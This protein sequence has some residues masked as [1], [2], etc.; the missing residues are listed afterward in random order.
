VRGPRLWSVPDGLWSG[1]LGRDDTG[2]RSA[3]RH[4]LDALGADLLLYSSKNRNPV[5]SGVMKELH[6]RATTVRKGSEG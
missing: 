5:L 6:P 1:S 2:L 4:V 3:R